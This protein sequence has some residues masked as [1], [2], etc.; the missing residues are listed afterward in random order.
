MTINMKWYT[1]EYPNRNGCLCNEFETI[2][3]A[4]AERAEVNKREQFGGY[5][6]VPYIIIGH[7]LTKVYDDD[8]Q[9][10]ESTK[11]EWKVNED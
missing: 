2:G 10:V 9:F 7:E 1:V 4:K 6:V 11:R 3:A 5:P 8:G